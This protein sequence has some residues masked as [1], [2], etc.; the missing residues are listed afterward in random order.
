MSQDSAAVASHPHNRGLAGSHRWGVLGVFLLLNVLLT[1]D[2]TIFTILLEPIKKEFALS[3]L[4]LGALSGT[5]FALCMGVAGLPLGALVDRVNRRNLAA[6]CLVFWSGMT[7]L[8]GVVTSVP[9]LILTR[10]MV[11]VGEAGGAPACLSMIADLFE[12]A[13]RATAMSIFALGPPVSTVISLSLGTWVVHAY[14]WRAALM[15][16]GAPGMILAL[17]M[18]LGMREPARSGA[19]S[20]DADAP[21]FAATFGMMRQ[22]PSFVHLIAGVFVSYLVLAGA[23]TF[24]NS[25]LVRVHHVKLA[26]I[27][28]FLGVLMSV[29]GVAASTSVGIVTD[30]LGRRSER[31]RGW[32][33]AIGSLGSV[34]FGWTFL[35]APSLPVVVSFVALFAASVTYWLGPAYSLCQSL[36]PARMRGKALA[37]MLLIGNTG[38]YVIAPPAVGYISDRMSAQFGTDGLRFALV[39]VVSLSLL[40]AL[41][42]FLMA[43]HLPADLGKIREGSIGG[44]EGGMVRGH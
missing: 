34:F 10:M 42:F 33:M 20:V 14:G 37:I 12:R 17:V 26:E 19:V 41:H 23:S 15:L 38:G 16:A 21:G 35:M 2:K 31:W 9:Q 4:M 43:R 25:F 18:V 5:F 44:D 24:T 11:G 3:D 29:V 8:C 7:M 32:V 22:T 1:L 13:R 6:A 40:A 30:T 27:G 39:G 28:P 36:A